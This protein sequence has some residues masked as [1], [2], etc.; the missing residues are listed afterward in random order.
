M[1]IRDRDI[2]PFVT[3][4]AG[5]TATLVLSGNA[6]PQS[7]F[8]NNAQI[9]VQTAGVPEPSSFALLGLGLVGFAARRKSRR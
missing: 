6:V 7:A 4:N 5:S 3:A 2:T 8:F 1:C 9:N